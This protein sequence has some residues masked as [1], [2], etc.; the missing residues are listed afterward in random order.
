MID[1]MKRLALLP[2][3]IVPF[4]AVTYAQRGSAPAMG[5]PRPGAQAPLELPQEKHLKNVKQLTNGGENAEA[6]FSFDGKRLSYQ[7]T[8]GHDCDQIYSM[9]IDGTDKHLVST[10]DGRTTCSHYSADNKSIFYAST[11]LGAK[12]CPAPPDQ[13][14]GYVWGIFDTYDIFSVGADGKNLKRLTN[15]PGYDAEATVGKDG[16]V[17]FTSVASGRIRARRSRSMRCWVDAVSG[18]WRLR[19]S[20]RA[21]RSSRSA[22]HPGSPVSVRAWCSTSMP[23]ASARRATARPMQ[24]GRAHV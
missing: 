6:Y 12:P 13:S 8:L 20:T 24:I 2:L 17:V 11:H 23:K 15:T 19:M 22:V 3:V 9:N 21:T 4:V 5:G 7:S 14:L 18:T 1:H 10:G 16:R